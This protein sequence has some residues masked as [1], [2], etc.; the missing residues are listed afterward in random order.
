MTTHSN[1][2]ASDEAEPHPHQESSDKADPEQQS[3]AGV[4]KDLQEAAEALKAST[5][6]EHDV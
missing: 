5:D 3:P 6:R 4:G 1:Q 2:S